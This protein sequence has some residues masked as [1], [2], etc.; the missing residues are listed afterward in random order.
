MRSRR[1]REFD[2]RLAA[3]EME[4][5]LVVGNRLV[6]GR[7][8]RV[9]QEVVMTRV[10]PF[11]SG[12]RNPHSMQTEMDRCLRTDYGAVFDVNE[13]NFCAGRGWRGSALLGGLRKGRRA[14]KKTCYDGDR[15]P[16]HPPHGRSPKD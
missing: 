8:V 10:G 11:G 13:F 2:F 15:R 12:W 14:D 5:V 1:Q 4:V 6:E 9:D 16:S 3:A 7:Q